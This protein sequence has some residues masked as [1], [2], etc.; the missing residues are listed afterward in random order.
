M[1]L[2]FVFRGTCYICC[3]DYFCDRVWVIGKHTFLTVIC[4]EKVSISHLH[5]K[6]EMYNFGRV[7]ECPVAENIRPAYM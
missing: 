5:H 7:N 4:P 2:L 6:P 3:I 1:P